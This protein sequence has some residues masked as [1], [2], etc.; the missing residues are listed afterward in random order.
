MLS[1]SNVEDAEVG[2]N[3]ISH[4]ARVFVYVSALGIHFQTQLPRPTNALLDGSQISLVGC[5]ESQS[6]H[7]AKLPHSTEGT[8]LVHNVE[9]TFTLYIGLHEGTS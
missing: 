6:G 7:G 5:S 4:N 9:P 2:R 3:V 1:A 8:A